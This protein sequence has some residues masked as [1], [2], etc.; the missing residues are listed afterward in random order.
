M[1]A[2]IFAFGRN[3]LSDSHVQRGEI[4]MRIALAQFALIGVP[5]FLIGVAIM[6][7]LP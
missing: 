5:L 4:E 1:M 7:A 6:A 3:L 2:R